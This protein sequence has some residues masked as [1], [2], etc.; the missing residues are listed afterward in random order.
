[1]YKELANKIIS[2]HFW[3]YSELDEILETL[4]DIWL[5][6]D[7]WKKVAS[8]VWKITTK[9]KPTIQERMSKS[10]DSFSDGQKKY[11]IAEMEW[12]RMNG[13]SVQFIKSL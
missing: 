11:L 4:N 6:N 13:T 8:E 12:G 7:N 10:W 1:M 3:I 9:G 2:S 5:L